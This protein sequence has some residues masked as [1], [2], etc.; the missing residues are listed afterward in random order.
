VL[1]DEPLSATYDADGFEQDWATLEATAN[2]AFPA[3][4][5]VAS[6]DLNVEGAR[7]LI[8]AQTNAAHNGIYVLI[9]EGDA[10]TPWKLRRCQQCRT[11]AQIPGSFVFTK[12]GT[13]YANTGWV[14]TVDDVTTFEVGTDDIIWT[15]FSG[16]GTFLA[17]TGLTLDG[18]EFSVNSSLTHVTELGTITAGVWNASTIA[19]NHG[20]TGQTSYTN[21]QLLIGN[22]TGNTLTKATLTAGSNI[23]ITNGAGSISIAAADTNL[24]VTAGTTDGPIITSS[25]GT[26]ATLPTA[27][28]SASGVIT[29]GNQTFAG[30]KTFSS[31][32]LPSTN[33]TINIGN[34]GARFDVVYANVFDGV[35]TQA[36]Y[37]DLAEIYT[38]DIEYPF[39]TIVM[40][41]GKKEITISE[42]FANTKIA[43]VISDKPAYLMNKDQDGLPVALKG[44][45]YCYV[46]GKVEAGDLIVTSHI[47]GV[48][49]SS[50]FI[51]GA[52][53][54]KAIEDKLT[55]DIELLEIL[56]I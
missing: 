25:T 16:A 50:E 43:G 5:D 27:S 21:G 54:G 9:V 56:V 36:K 31:N 47:A 26:N 4:D 51:G 55:E 19:V 49:T 10:G 17:G 48:G 42:G 7:I 11:S 33:G 44:R 15:Q 32:I 38:S 53:V 13:V 2:G 39:G 45:V 1:V 37:A 30:T 18:N 34:N 14:A 12:L 20:G 46:T 6:V 52:V 29:T 22:T 23:T 41:G 28:A 35:A 3:V 40:F 24:G 8:T